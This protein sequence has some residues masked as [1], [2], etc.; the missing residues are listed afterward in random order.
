[1]TNNFKI[2]TLETTG[3]KPLTDL[4]ALFGGWPMTLSNWE[5]SS[6]VWQDATVAGR[7]L[8]GTYYFLSVFNYLDSLNTD[9]SRI[10]V[11]FLIVE[12]F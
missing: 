4:L 3:L 2:V 8:Y 11:C 12:T 1:M 7:Q 6:F 5:E 9:Q 10:Y